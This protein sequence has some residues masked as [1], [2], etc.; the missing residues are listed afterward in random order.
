[1]T[2]IRTIL[3]SILQRGTG[4]KVR[5]VKVKQDKKRIAELTTTTDSDLRS[6][7]SNLKN[8][9]VLPVDKLPPKIRNG[10][11][12]INADVSTGPGTHWVGLYMGSNQEYT[13]HFDPFGGAIDPRILKFAKTGSKRVVSIKTQSQ[14]IDASSCGYWAIYFLKEMQRGVT[15]GEFLS[16]IDDNDQEKNE[17]MLRKHF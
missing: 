14:D 11:F 15:I 13:I 8:L 4:R 7:G 2:E 5:K 9:K 17:A 3:D 1:M 10:S 16:N 6:L 12:V